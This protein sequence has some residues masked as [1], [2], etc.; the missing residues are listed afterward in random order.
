MRFSLFLCV[1][2]PE[3]FI[4]NSNLPVCRQCIHYSPDGLSTCAKFGEKNIVT[5]EI[6]H[7][8]AASCRRDEN[9]CG[10]KGV[11]FE[12]DSPLGIFLKHFRHPLYSYTVGTFVLTL[13]FINLLEFI[14]R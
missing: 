14:N 1:L 2:G 3:K 12:K 6:N 10:E 11:F 4:K 9:K 8:Y 5:N 7:A 13:F